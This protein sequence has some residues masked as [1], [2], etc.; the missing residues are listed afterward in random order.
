MV[1]HVYYLYPLLLIIGLFIP[2]FF[3]MFLLF[4]SNKKLEYN[5]NNEYKEQLSKRVY[6]QILD[7]RDG[8]II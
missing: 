4:L 6:K 5:L 7:E 8:K 2:C 3:S 1:F